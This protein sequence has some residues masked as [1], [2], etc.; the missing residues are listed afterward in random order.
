VTVSPDGKRLATAS[1]K[2]TI[3]VWDAQ[4]GQELLTLKGHADRVQ[5]VAFSPDGKRLASAAMDRTVK[6]WDAQTG[7]EL[8]SLHTHWRPSGVVFSPDGHRLASG[9]YDG[10]VTIWDATPLPEKRSP[11]Q[12]KQ[13]TYVDLQPKANQKLTDTF[14]GRPKGNTLASLPKGEQT[15]QGVQFKIADGLAQLGS[16][17]LQAQKP[18]RVD[19]IRVGKAFAR[20]HLLHA[21]QFGS[22]LGIIQDDTPIAKYEVHYEGG[23]TETIPVVYGQDVRNWWYSDSEKGVTRG[24]VAWTGENGATK[25]TMGRRRIRLYLGTWENP[26]PTTRVERIDYVKVG[27]TPAAP[28]CVAMTLEEK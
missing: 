25:D 7:Q 1:G 21:T 24:K 20:L 9:S 5:S 10:T 13:F 12:T 8:L 27:D 18:D 14:A 11:E 26:H 3:K 2:E 16:E 4:T 22:G 23:G 6:V 17:L 28:F 19:G 15:L